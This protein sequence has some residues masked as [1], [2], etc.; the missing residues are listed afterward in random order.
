M[1][2]DGNNGVLTGVVQVLQALG[3]LVELGRGRGYRRTYTSR[4]RNP[5][6]EESLLAAVAESST[7][8]SEA[9]T[10]VPQNPASFHAPVSDEIHQDAS[11]R[12]A[13]P[14][15]DLQQLHVNDPGAQIENNH[16]IISAIDSAITRNANVKKRMKPSRSMVL[17]LI[18]TKLQVCVTQ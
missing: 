15:L 9:A 6:R 12:P 5:K 16:K 10:T 17:D 11:S 13:I 14:K 2:T 8:S 1:T 7:Y 18:L 3:G 4:S